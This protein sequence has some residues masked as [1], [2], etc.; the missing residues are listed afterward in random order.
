MGC[1]AADDITA[2][3][4]FA[5]LTTVYGPTSVSSVNGWNTFILTSPFDWTGSSNIVVEV[6]FDNA[7]IT[8]NDNVRYTIMSYNATQRHFVTGGGVAGCALPTPSAQHN[9]LPNT[10]MQICPPDP[11]PF[12][13]SWSPGTGL[14]STSISNPLAF[15]TSSIT[16]YVTVTGGPCPVRDSLV[17][18]MS[19]CVLPAEMLNLRAEHA[20]DKVRLN[21]T[22]LN[23]HNTSH[24]I[25]E[26]SIDEGKNWSGFA[27]TS[28]KGNF[29]GY[30]EYSDYDLN[31]A[32]GENIYRL[33]QVDYDGYWIYSNAVAV[34]FENKEGLLNVYPNPARE[35]QSF[36][37]EFQSADE[38]PVT[39]EIVDIF[40]RTVEKQEYIVLK[41]VSTIEYNLRGI[42]Q[43][44][45]FVK[46]SFKGNTDVKKIIVVK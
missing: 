14:S 3:T 1:T 29:R 31:P 6:C 36:F 44:T 10:R 9:Q 39:I 17:V 7:G 11:P 12:V 43:G 18:D 24:F 35:G 15:P 40:G 33:R 20:G 37:V 4:W 8:A 46:A 5:G 30:F 13:Y 42:A 25:L 21:W 38:T 28:A 45:Y 27:S 19:A 23:E 26:K 16:Y 41:G 32:M 22:T 2:G 34:N